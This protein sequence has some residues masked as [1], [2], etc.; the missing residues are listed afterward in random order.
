MFV[1]GGWHWLIVDEWRGQGVYRSRDAVNWT[2]QGLIGDRPGADP[3]DRRFMRHAD[4]VVV[5]DHGALYYFTHPEW[6]ELNPKEGPPDVAARKTAVHH[7]RLTV[8]G[9]V[10]VFERGVAAGV[11]LLRG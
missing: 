10:L 2:R 4:V 7:G 11:A 3:M 8:V 1:L 6:D 9:D 5:G